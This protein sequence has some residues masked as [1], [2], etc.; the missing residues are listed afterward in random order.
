M[1]TQEEPVVKYG[2]QRFYF[3]VDETSK[4]LVAGNP[5][6]QI[7][8]YNLQNNNCKYFE[9]AHYESVAAVSMQKEGN[10]IVTGAGSRQF[11]PER[12]DTSDSEEFDN[13]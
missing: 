10:L 5:L 11:R 1:T 7:I 2:S 9:S 13:E 3:D 6:G 12:E 8:A 4:T